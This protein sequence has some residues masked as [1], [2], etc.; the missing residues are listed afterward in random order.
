M[1]L[2]NHSFAHQVLDQWIEPG[3]GDL[4]YHCVACPRP[5]GQYRNMPS[6]W[7]DSP[8]SWGYQY[9]WNIDGNF[10]AQH[11]ASRSAENNVYLYPGTAMFNHPEVEAK[12]RQSAVDDSDLPEDEVS[13]SHKHHRPRFSRLSILE[14]AKSR[15]SRA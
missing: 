3:A 12:L 1:S 13:G 6:N 4:M 7:R 5:S 11:T 9:A 15:V 8:Y 14:T 2:I 10:E